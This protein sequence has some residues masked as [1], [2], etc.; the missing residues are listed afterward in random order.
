[1]LG[2]GFEDLLSEQEGKV[3]QMY[4][5]KCLSGFTNP[6]SARIPVIGKQCRHLQCFDLDSYVT[7]SCK[8]ANLSKRWTC[9]KD[10]AGPSTFVRLV[11][12][13]NIHWPATWKADQH[14][15]R[16]WQRRHVWQAR[17]DPPPVLDK[18]NSTTASAGV[19]LS[20]AFRTWHINDAAQ[21]RLPTPRA[22]GR[23]H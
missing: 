22:Q 7:A 21:T 9:I 16:L 2:F 18:C 19:A 10:L 14:V 5:C 1:M 12:M 11:V 23:A 17:G 4:C 8:Q 15:R 13:E 3:R 20:H 6:R